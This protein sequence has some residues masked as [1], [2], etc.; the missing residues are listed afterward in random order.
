M[1]R[2]I[3]LL[4]LLLLLLGT[5]LAEENAY[6]LP[7]DIYFENYPADPA[8]FTETTYHDDSLDVRIETGNFQGSDY[9]VAYFTVKSPTQFRTVTAGRP[10]ENV[11]ALPSEMGRQMNAVLMLN[12]EFYVQRTRNIFIYRQGQEY[13]NEPDPVKDVLIIDDKGDFHIYTSENKKEEIQAFID[14]GGKIIN[15]FS[16]GP[17]LVI[18][19]EAV[20]LKKDYYFVPDE[21]RARSAV[22]QVGPLS[23]AFIYCPV[24]THKTMRDI[25][26]KLNMQQSYNLDG[27]NSSVLMFNGEYIGG[28]SKKTERE[29]SDILYVVSAVAPD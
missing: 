24:A 14:G 21:Y 18:D 15:A 10:N 4:C 17:G 3:C 13:R 20:R 7:L 16:F 23:Y 8:G 1:K 12:G 28:K 5:A 25:S 2:T 11:T 22:A 27:G 19:G 6:D 26:A 29:Q 9:Y